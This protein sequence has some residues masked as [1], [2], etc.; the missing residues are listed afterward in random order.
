M[1]KL[2][3]Y[4]ALD[5]RPLTDAP[6]TGHCYIEAILGA[7]GVRFGRLAI[8]TPEGAV[9]DA[10]VIDRLP[11]DAV[12]AA[13][14]GR[15]RG[16]D[17]IRF[18]PNDAGA[19]QLRESFLTEHTHDD[20]EVRFFLS[21]KGAFYLH[22]ENKVIAV[23]CS[24]GELLRIPAGV[25]HWFDPGNESDFVVVRLLTEANTWSASPTG[26][27]IAERL[28]AAG[29]KTDFFAPIQPAARA[30]GRSGLVRKGRP[31]R[32][33]KKA[34]GQFRRLS[35]T[36][37]ISWFARV[38]LLPFLSVGRSLGRRLAIAGAVDGPSGPHIANSN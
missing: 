9:S 14:L 31:L 3:L 30:A 25:R 35:Q 18:D 26:S 34:L 6:V 19:R 2:R 37:Q 32:G 24:K 16:A 7:V 12:D 15:Y 29:A 28:H 8:E 22:V 17:V 21:G 38:R 20:D 33:Q 11:R 13:Q 36:N 27:D 4:D 1:A 10:K 23:E 5:W